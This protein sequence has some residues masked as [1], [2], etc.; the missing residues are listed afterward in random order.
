[1]RHLYKITIILLVAIV[2]LFLGGC[3]LSELTKRPIMLFVDLDKIIDS[4]DF[5]EIVGDEVSFS[6][7]S[8]SNKKAFAGNAKSRY[9]LQ[10][11]DEE[12]RFTKSLSGKKY[13]FNEFEAD[14]GFALLQNLADLKEQVLSIGGTKV[15]NIISY[16]TNS[17]QRDSKDSF[18]C[19]V[20]D[21]SITVK[22]KADFAR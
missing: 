3:S 7:G 8:G 6:F 4:E 21:S 1:M 19:I 17:S 9:R 16:Y 12:W 10:I 11:G 2:G 5:I 18:Q 22:L 15:I 20:R 13:K 14:C